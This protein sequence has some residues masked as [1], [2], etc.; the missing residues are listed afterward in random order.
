MDKLLDVDRFSGR[1]KIHFESFRPDQIG[2]AEIYNKSA[3]SNLGRGPRRGAVALVRPM[4][5][6]GIRIRSAVL[7]QC[8]T[9]NPLKGR[10]VNWLHF[11]IHI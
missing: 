8:S 6:N 11:A 4:V 7:P 10:G 9:F 3:Q 1:Q 2:P 5:P